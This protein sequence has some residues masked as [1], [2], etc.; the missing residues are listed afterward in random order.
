MNLMNKKQLYENI[1]QNVSKQIKRSLTE[2]YDDDDERQLRP[3]DLYKVTWDIRKRYGSR[4]KG[5]RFR[6]IESKSY[7]TDS[8]GAYQVF[9]NIK[10]KYQ[11]ADHDYYAEVLKIEKMYIIKATG[12]ET[13]VTVEDE[14]GTYIGDDVLESRNMRY[15]KRINEVRSYSNSGEYPIDQSK[16][17]YQIVNELIDLCHSKDDDELYEHADWLR[18][19][20]MDNRFKIDYD[21]LGKI[22]AT[23]LRMV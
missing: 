14:S 13:W 18:S 16:L 23:R 5:L 4:A 2:D 9:K 19:L 12:K 20:I 3:T 8:Y 15:K 1:M 6:K 7:T 11:S 21:N 10:Y 22:V 17:A